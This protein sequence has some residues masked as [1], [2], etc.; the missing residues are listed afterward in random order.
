MS[1]KIAVMYLGK[2]I[3]MATSKDIYNNALHPYTKALLSSI[4]KPDPA[5][6][7]DHIIL[8]GEVPSVE[9]PPLGCNFNTRCGYVKDICHEKEPGLIQN[10]KNPEHLTACHFFF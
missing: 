1:D 5:S 10:K 3:E 8:Q 7:S 4:P 2:I 6:Y 9:N